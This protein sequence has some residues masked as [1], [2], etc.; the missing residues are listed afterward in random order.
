VGRFKNIIFAI[1]IAFSSLAI[2]IGILGTLCKCNPCKKS[3]CW[4]VWF[5]IML[6]FV[7]IVTLIIG[8]ILTA[9]SFSSPD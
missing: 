1:L 4:P 8:S 9:I 5:G 7:W 3:I 6:F 2:L